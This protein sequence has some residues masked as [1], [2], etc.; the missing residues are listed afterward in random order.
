MIRRTLASLIDAE[1]KAGQDEEE[2]HRITREELK[3]AE[4]EGLIDGAH[5]DLFVDWY[6]LGGMERGIG[7]VELATMPAAMRTD[8]MYILREMGRIRRQRRAAA[9]AK[10]GLK[11]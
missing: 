7:I 5:L 4:N 1:E 9:K 8:L 10:K 11:K 6:Q 3:A 2:P